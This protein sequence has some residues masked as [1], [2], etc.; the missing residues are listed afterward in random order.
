MTISAR[1]AEDAR[2]GRMRR[3]RSEIGGVRKHIGKAGGGGIHQVQ[4]RE[5]QQFEGGPQ[6]ARELVLAWET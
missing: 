6:Q 4:R 5:A 3:E 2:V 1:G